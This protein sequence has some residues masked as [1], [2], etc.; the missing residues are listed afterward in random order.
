M[1]Q[2]PLY[3]VYAIK[4][5]HHER[6]ASENFIGGDPQ[7]RTIT[8]DYFVWLAL[9]G[10]RGLGVDTRFSAAAAERRGRHLFRCPTARLRLLGADSRS[11]GAVV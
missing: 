3:E 7:H 4:Y 1:A 11:R 6:N 2:N 5:A 9:G 8:L 10:G